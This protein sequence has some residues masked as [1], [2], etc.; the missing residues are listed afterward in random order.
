MA[1]SLERQR[2][3]LL[4]VQRSLSRSERLASVGRLAAGVAHEVGNPIAA[5]L[6][7]A[8]VASRERGISQRTR[9][10]LARMRDEALRIRTLVRELL[11]LARSEELVIGPHD[12]HVL[13]GRVVERLSPQ[14]LLDGIE[15]E[16]EVEEGLPPLLVDGRRVEQ[17]L[18]NL[19]ENAAHAVREG[20]RDGSVAT[21]RIRVTRGCL[22]ARARRRRGDAPLPSNEAGRDPEALALEVIDNG[23]GIDPE[24]VAHVF[25]PFFTTKDP[26]M[27]TGLGL[28]N[29]HRTA[30][31]LGGM[32]EVESRPGR[33]RFSLVL[34]VADTD[35][36]HGPPAH[37]DHR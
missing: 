8:E 2:D 28:W 12:V 26:G 13:V 25:D 1:A 21:I 17:V 7:Y 3:A 34:P 15:L 23:P 9:D 20:I 19:I 18:V 30:E 4:E 10:T 37:T 6:G 32:L 22:R 36:E 24:D 14:P 27:G 33:T 5:I 11:D 16:V 35:E 29:G 31:L